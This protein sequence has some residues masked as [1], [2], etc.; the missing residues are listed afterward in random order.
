MTPSP[1]PHPR[2]P[3][4]SHPTRTHPTHTLPVHSPH[5]HTHAPSHSL[6]G[7]LRAPLVALH[8]D[9]A[10]IAPYWHQ[11]VY[12]RKASMQGAAALHTVIRANATA[13]DCALAPSLV[14][15]ALAQLGRHLEP[16]T[17]TRRRTTRPPSGWGRLNPPDASRR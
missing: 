14:G 12:A 17:A 7:S 13:A 10:L 16:S 9:G 4:S 8:A 2:I 3:T 6:A 11:E 15:L 1:I 5:T